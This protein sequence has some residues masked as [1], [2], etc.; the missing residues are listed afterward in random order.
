MSIFSWLFGS[1]STS[2]YESITVLDPDEFKNRINSANAQLIDVRTPKQ[3]DA[4]HI[5]GAKNINFFSGRFS[6]E[7]E[8]LDKDRP[9]FLYCRSGSRSKQTAKR[10]TV[11]GFTEVYDLKGG[12]LNYN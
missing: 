11:N 8:K 1:R 2:Q 10:L 4:G 5:K 12:I 7:F 3:F 9:V 6:I